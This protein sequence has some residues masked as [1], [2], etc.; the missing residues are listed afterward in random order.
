[1]ERTGTPS[2]NTSAVHA[3][4][5]LLDNHVGSVYVIVSCSTTLIW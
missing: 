1:M 2:V 3:I 4:T 5:F